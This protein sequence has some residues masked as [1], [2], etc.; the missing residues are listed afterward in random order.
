MVNK[1]IEQFYRDIADVCL[2]YKISGIAGVWFSGEG[3]DEF[4][5]LAFYDVTTEMKTVVQMITEKYE[6]WAG[7]AATH[8]N[9]TTKIHEMRSN[10]PGKT[11]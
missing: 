6:L 1:E 8:T 7:E 3:H 11:N 10:E 9:V 4:G 2:K 5:Q